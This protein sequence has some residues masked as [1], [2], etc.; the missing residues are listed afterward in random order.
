MVGSSY[1][2]S[3]SDTPIRPELND[4]LYVLLLPDFPGVSN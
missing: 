3:S 1:S 2:P 4:Q